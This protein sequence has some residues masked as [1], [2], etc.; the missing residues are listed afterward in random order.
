MRPLQGVDAAMPQEDPRVEA[1]RLLS[2]AP[3][4]SCWAG[5]TGFG[6]GVHVLHLTL[7]RTL[8]LLKFLLLETENWLLKS[9]TAK[10]QAGLI[11]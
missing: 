9:V 8:S 11:G 10:I 4:F 6:F 7:V 2:V 3:P 5:G 1:S